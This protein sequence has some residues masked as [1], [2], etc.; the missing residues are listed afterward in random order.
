MKFRRSVFH[1]YV[2]RSRI[3]DAL[4]QH[5]GDAGIGTT[6]HY[7]VPIHQ[8]PAYARGLAR[9]SPANQAEPLPETMS[10]AAE[11]LSLPMFAELDLS[12]VEVVTATIRKF[13]GKK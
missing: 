7:P 2:I 12:Q 3:R 10:A 1:Q 11:I 13:A 6:I 5:L 9:S 4:V 8:Q